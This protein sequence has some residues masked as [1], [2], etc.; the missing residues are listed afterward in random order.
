MCLKL[1]QSVQNTIIKDNM[2]KK[3]ELK[4]GR[5]SSW[6]SWRK[7]PDEAEPTKLEGSAS[8]MNVSTPDGEVSNINKTVSG[9]LYSCLGII[10][11][12]FK[13]RLMLKKHKPL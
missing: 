4:K 2:P 12:I 11:S 3:R 13:P 8:N 9:T 10:I 6:F 1:F 7:A 5:V